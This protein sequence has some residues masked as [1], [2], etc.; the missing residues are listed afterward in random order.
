VILFFLFNAAMNEKIP[1]R[2]QEPARRDGRHHQDLSWVDFIDFSLPPPPPPA[3]LKLKTD[4]EK[5]METDAH[6]VSDPM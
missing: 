4:R 6:W 1:L 2:R 3:H 5:E